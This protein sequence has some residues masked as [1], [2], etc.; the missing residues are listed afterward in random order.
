ME[1]MRAEFDPEVR[2]WYLTLADAPVSRTVH[3][4]DEV[5]VDLDEGDR[6]VGVEFLLAPTDLEPVVLDGLLNQF[7]DIRKALAELQALAVA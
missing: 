7:P 5:L 1:T 4:S 6:V 3:I 2:A